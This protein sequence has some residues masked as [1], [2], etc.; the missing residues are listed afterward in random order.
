MKRLYGGIGRI[1]AEIL[2]REAI[3]DVLKSYG[4]DIVL[5][6]TYLIVE[7]RTEEG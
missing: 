5:N 7:F 2:L 3:K 6:D 1:E 4:N